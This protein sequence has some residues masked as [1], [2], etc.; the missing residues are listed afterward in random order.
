MRT[1]FPSLSSLPGR[2][3][4][5][6]VVNVKRDYTVEAVR[7]TLGILNMF[8][9][10]D[11]LT[12]M[13]I[14]RLTG[15][16]K[17]T[18]LRLVYT[19]RR[20]GFLAFDEDTKRYSLG[21]AVFE[22]G[23]RKFDGMDV[24]KIALPHLE[25]TANAAGLICYLGVKSENVLVMLE[26][27]F[28]RTVP[29]W[30]QLTRA[31]ETMPLYATG[32]GRLFLADMSDEEVE[33]YFDSVELRRITPRTVTDR[34][35]LLKM[36]AKVRRDGFCLL[37]GEW[38]PY[39]HSVCAPLFNHTGELAAGISVCGMK[40]MIGGARQGELTVMLKETAQRISEKLGF[41]SDSY[42]PRLGVIRA[43]S[44]AAETADETTGRGTRKGKRG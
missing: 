22:L 1:P 33:R 35:A 11:A 9:T 26:K 37:R 32:I 3:D 18:A 29:T 21:L 8:K 28:P 15:I 24:R 34:A 12:L 19:L 2:L 39:I 44:D 38:E 7:K 17:S 5:R 10:S 31:E 23:N 41:R 14:S 42:T 25:E 13:E 16:G 27:V 6:P 20:E 40:E 30:A 36:I 4:R 43:R